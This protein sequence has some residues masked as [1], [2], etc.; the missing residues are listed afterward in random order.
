V[1]IQE[2]KVHLIIYKCVNSEKKVHL[3]IYTYVLIQKRKFI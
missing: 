3:F 1:L 2:K